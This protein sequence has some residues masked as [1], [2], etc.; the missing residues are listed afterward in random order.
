[1]QNLIKQAAME[2]QGSRQ[3]SVVKL[4]LSEQHP[5]NDNKYVRV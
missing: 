4:Q 5:E 3:L 2:H 1:M